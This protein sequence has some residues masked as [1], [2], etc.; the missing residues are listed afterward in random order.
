MKGGHVGELHLLRW[1][2]FQKPLNEIQESF[3][4]NGE[5][6]RIDGVDY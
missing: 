6:S 5:K 4:E 2:I 3:L 1:Q